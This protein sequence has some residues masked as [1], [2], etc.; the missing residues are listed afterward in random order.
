MLHATFAL[1][2]NAVWKTGGPAYDD[3]VKVA[4]GLQAKDAI[5]GFMYMGTDT[6]GPGPLPRPDWREFVQTWPAR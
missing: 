6:E 2:F 1:G 3:Q 5:V 4:L